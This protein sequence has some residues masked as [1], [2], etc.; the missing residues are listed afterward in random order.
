[1]WQLASLL[2]K[3][4]CQWYATVNLSSPSY[5]DTEIALKYLTQCPHASPCSA[6]DRSRSWDWAWRWSIYQLGNSPVIFNLIIH[7]QSMV[8]E[9]MS[10]TIIH[11]FSQKILEKWYIL[12]IVS[13]WPLS[14]GNRDTMEAERRSKNSHY[15]RRI[16]GHL[17]SKVASNIFEEM[18]KVILKPLNS[19]K[20]KKS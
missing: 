16:Q 7:N 14:C 15:Q 20:K 18:W 8:H 1:M 12:L 9:R 3:H 4:G 10:E 6:L 19:S 13:Y 17:S 11:S 5:G 2:Q